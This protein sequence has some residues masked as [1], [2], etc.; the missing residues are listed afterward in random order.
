LVRGTSSPGKGGS[1]HAGGPPFARIA[2]PPPCGPNGW[3]AGGAGWG[4]RP[5]VEPGCE[6]SGGVALGSCVAGMWEEDA[7]AGALCG[8]RA[9]AVYPALYEGS[10]SRRCGSVGACGVCHW[11]PRPGTAM[12]EVAGRMPQYWW[13]PG[14]AAGWATDAMRRAFVFGGAHRRKRLGPMPIA[15]PVAGSGTSV[16]RHTW[17]DE[18]PGAAAPWTAL[19]PLGG[20]PFSPPPKKRV[21]V[22]HLAK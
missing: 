6:S 17:E 12:E 20:R 1:A 21:M 22:P 9:A 14:D 19:P 5:D 11:S 2:R 18:A 16:S 7:V 10:D 13:E 15:G 4:R 3:L 8:T